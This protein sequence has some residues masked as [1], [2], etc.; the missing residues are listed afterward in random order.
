VGSGPE[1]GRLRRYAAELGI[2]DRVELRS[3]VPYDEMPA[4]YAQASC[5]VLLSLPTWFW[6]EQFGMVLAEALAAGVPII[7]STSGAIPEVAGPTARYV[8]PGDHVGLAGELA[9]MTGARHEIADQE[10]VER[11]SAHAAA[12]RL[13]EAYDQLLKT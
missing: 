6:E 5:L 1:D 2:G 11:F 8:A 3:F 10:R 12:R 7:A 9:K 4:L 13:A